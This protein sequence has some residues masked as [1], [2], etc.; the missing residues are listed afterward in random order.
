MTRL[1]YRGWLLAGAVGCAFALQVPATAIA[2]SNETVL[3]AFG[4]GTDGRY[5]RA[6]LVHVKGKLYGTTYEGGTGTGGPSGAGTIFS[7]KPANG[8][9]KVV[10]SLCS[11]LN[12]ADGDDA[13]SGLIRF[14]GKL[15]GTTDAGGA[16]DNGTVFSFDP[17]TGAESVVYSFCSQQ[18]C[19]DGQSPYAGL[20]HVK[21][22]LYGTA[23]EGGANGSGTVF[24]I[25]PVTGA[26]TTLY[27]FGSGTD[28]AYPYAGL[29]DVKGTLYGTTLKGG[30]NGSGTV[31]SINPATGAETVLYSFCSLQNCA[32]GEYLY[33]GL[34]D[35]GGTLYGTTFDGG[36]T[37]SGTVFSINPATGA[38][39]VLHSFTSGADG[40]NPHA[41]LIDVNGTLYSTTMEGGPQNGGTVFSIDPVTGAETVLYSFCSQQN[42]TDGQYPFGD[43]IQ[44][45]GNLY[46]TTD[47]GGT[48]NEGTVFAL[49]P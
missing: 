9:E 32:D 24:S 49:T 14:D 23:L 42:C 1:D 5:P 17:A 7:I 13:E 37:G 36:T 26:E 8:K 21:G 31:F 43:L 41:G 15:Y 16:S 34:I 3:H 12:C 6:S 33:G 48:N 19:A 45:K 29:I 27:S 39:T 40:G 25:D 47:E 44:V 4:N 35:V 38:E 20:V 11:Q 18:N 46:G 22:K 2:Q 10:Y 30:T 28:G